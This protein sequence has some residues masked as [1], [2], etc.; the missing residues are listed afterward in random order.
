MWLNLYGREAVWNKFKNG[1]KHQKCIFWPVEIKNCQFWKTPFFWV[2]HFDF[3][4]YNFFFFASFPWKQVKV[5]WLAR[6]GRNFDDYSGFQP[7]ITPSKHFSHRCTT[8]S[9]L[10][11]FIWGTWNILVEILTHNIK[12]TIF[13]QIVSALEKFPSFKS[14]RTCMYCDQRLNSKKNSFRGNYLRRYGI[15][16]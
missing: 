2:C 10:W 7:K 3:F 13:L 6:M 15:C 4:F 1:L 5:Y 14:F 8:M 11:W 16:F 9:K 12:P